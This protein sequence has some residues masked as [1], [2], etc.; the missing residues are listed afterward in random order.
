VK[1]STN[2]PL[3]DKKSNWIDYNAGVLLDNPDINTL[4]ED[5]YSFIKNIVNGEQKA[6][7][8]INGYREISIFKTGVTL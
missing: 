7:N 1:I 6:K 3:F 8:E 4:A 5:F 2:T